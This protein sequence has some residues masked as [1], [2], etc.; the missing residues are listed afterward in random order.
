[1]AKT[2]T[3]L[4]VDVVRHGRVTGT[5]TAEETFSGILPSTQST[6][7]E[8]V[9]TPREFPNIRN[10]LGS[11]RLLDRGLRNRKLNSVESQTT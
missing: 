10:G 8:Q 6:Y 4:G 7:R 1:M 2:F 5:V 11:C 3:P 9:R